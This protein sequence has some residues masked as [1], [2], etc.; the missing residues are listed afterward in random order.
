VRGARRRAGERCR[1]ASLEKL[2]WS[3]GLPG[4]GKRLLRRKLLDPDVAERER[5]GVV[6]EA[7]FSG[8]GTVGEFAFGEVDFVDHFTV[9]LHGEFVVLIHDVEV[10]PL[11]GGF[12]GAF[13]GRDAGDDAAAV[14]VV[15][16]FVRA[17]TGGIVDLDFDAFGDGIVDVAD[18]EVEPAVA[19]LLHLVIELDLEV[20]VIFLGPKVGGPTGPAFFALARGEGG[21][22]VFEGPVAGGVPVGGDIFFEQ[23]G[24]AVL[25]GERGGGGEEGEK[26]GWEFHGGGGLVQEGVSGGGETLKG[27]LGFREEFGGMA[28]EDN[29]I[30]RD[31][32]AATQDAIASTGDGVATTG[33]GVA[34]TGD[35]V[36][37]TGDGVATTGDGVATT[38]DDV[39]TTGDDVATTG[40]GIATT[41][42]DV[43]TA[44][45]DVATAGDD[46]ATTGDGVA[47]TGD[48]VV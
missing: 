9:E 16:F 22:A 40:D 21:D 24:P 25:G 12:G 20:G 42:D 19:A 35:G 17:P 37:T 38:G 36:A 18:A 15:E 30:S 29:A 31:V 33:D 8:L 5:E 11:A 34:T 28:L 4:L 32:I 3:S 39:A 48:G 1:L 44:G 7:D 13:G 2:A 47:T 23:I 10:V 27:M 45:D 41:G 26:E 43:A 14:V 46:V 6:L